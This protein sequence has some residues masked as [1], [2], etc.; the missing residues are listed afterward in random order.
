[1][2]VSTPVVKVKFGRLSAYENSLL[3][4]MCELLIQILFNLL[5]LPTMLA[6]PTPTL[7]SRFYPASRSRSQMHL[8]DVALRCLL[9]LDT[10]NQEAHI[11]DK[12]E[13]C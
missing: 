13:A 3:L 11:V 10:L 2:P 6:S 7:A 5:G 12:T 8:R 9:L 1:M 4:Q